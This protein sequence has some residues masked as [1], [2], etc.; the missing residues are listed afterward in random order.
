MGSSIFVRFGGAQTAK[1]PYSEQWVAVDGVFGSDSLYINGLPGTGRN[2]SAAYCFVTPLRWVVSGT[3]GESISLPATLGGMVGALPLVDSVYGGDSLNFGAVYAV[4]SYTESFWSSGVGPY[5]HW[6]SIDV[7]PA[8]TKR[9]TSVTLLTRIAG[10]V[11]IKDFVIKASNDNMSWTSLYTGIYV[12][13]HIAQSFPFSNTGDYRFYR[14]EFTN[15]YD[16]TYPT[17]TQ[18]A[19]LEFFE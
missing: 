7:G 18:V 1:L 10:S 13:S 19:M 12:N 5:P 16:S 3:M 8:I 2:C 11:R 9:F 6:I 14:V 17:I 4:D 15:N